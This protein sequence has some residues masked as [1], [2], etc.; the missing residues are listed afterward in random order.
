MRG[1][2]FELAP[3]FE[4]KVLISAPV[5]AWLNDLGKLA[6]PAVRRLAPRRLG[7]L[8]AGVDHDVVVD[9]EGRRLVL[10]IF[11]TDFKAGW[12]EFGTERQAARPSLRP[13]TATAIP[14]AK[15]SESA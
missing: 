11:N 12:Y 4:A 9:T 14:A 6:V 1:T 8:E 13:G 2:R 10:R 7:F 3:D 5:A 15:W